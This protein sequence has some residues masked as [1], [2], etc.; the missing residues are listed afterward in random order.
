M[1]SGSRGYKDLDMTEPLA[2]T[3]ATI[4]FH[5]SLEKPFWDIFKFLV[6]LTYRYQLA[7]CKASSIQEVVE[8][9]TKSIATMC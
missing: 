2:H 7:V 1:G 6:V 3:L 9:V 4:N 5:K 8:N